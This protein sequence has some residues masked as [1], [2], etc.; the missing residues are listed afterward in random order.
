MYGLAESIDI[1]AT[2]LVD[3]PAHVAEALLLTEGSL[4]VRRMRLLRNGEGRPIELS[5]S[6]FDPDLAEVAPRLLEPARLVGG[7]AKYLAEI[8]GRHAAYGRD[9]VA[10]RLATQDEARWLEVTVPAA[11]LVYRFTVYGDDD[12][13]IQTDDAT[14]PSDLWAFRQEYPLAR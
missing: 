1:L 12:A 13:P 10:A 4:A 14:Y 7:T 2:D 3:A 8:T 5:T 11:V 9:Q 6:W